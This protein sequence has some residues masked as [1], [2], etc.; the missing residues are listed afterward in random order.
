MRKPKRVTIAMLR[1]A[2]E[3]APPSMELVIASDEEGNDFH[4]VF[5][6]ER[7]TAGLVFWPSHESVLDAVETADSI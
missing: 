4:P 7:T 2:I 6:V 1:E 3:N 5:M